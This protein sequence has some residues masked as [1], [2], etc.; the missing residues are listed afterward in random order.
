MQPNKVN[1]TAMDYGRWNK[2]DGVWAEENESEKWTIKCG[3]KGMRCNN[4]CNHIR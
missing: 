1:L 3:L 4:E 2:W